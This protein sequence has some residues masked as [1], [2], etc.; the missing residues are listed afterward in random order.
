M[1][2][3]DSLLRYHL[4]KQVSSEPTNRLIGAE[5]SSD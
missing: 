2:T 1:I 5:Q 3:A 4:P